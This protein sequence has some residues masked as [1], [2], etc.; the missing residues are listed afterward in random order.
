M[1]SELPELIKDMEEKNKTISEVKPRKK[2]RDDD[3]SYNSQHSVR[4]LQSPQICI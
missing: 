4:T 3:G 2:Q 1:D